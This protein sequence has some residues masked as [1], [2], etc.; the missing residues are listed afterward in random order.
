MVA[1][2]TLLKHC[3]RGKLCAH[4]VS[5][6]HNRLIIYQKA[7]DWQKMA[8]EVKISQKPQ[9]LH[10]YFLHTKC[11]VAIQYGHWLQSSCLILNLTNSLSSNC[12]TASNAYMVKVWGPS[13]W[14]SLNGLA[15]PPTFVPMFFRKSTN[16]L[17]HRIL[18]STNHFFQ[19]TK[20]I[21][22]QKYRN[23]NKR[24]IVSHILSQMN[25]HAGLDPSWA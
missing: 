2:Q 14:S 4:Q 25:Q 21:F 16:N 6:L 5:V 22:E 7:V 9:N 8:Q 19:R 10:V 1:T 20:V 12:C 24:S 11:F 15:A 3:L 18:R 23:P 13:G 17:W